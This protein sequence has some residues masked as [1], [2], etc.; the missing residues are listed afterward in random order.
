MYEIYAHTDGCAGRNVPLVECQ[1]LFRGHAG[2][3]VRY[4]GRNSKV[5]FNAC[6]EIWQLLQ[7]LPSGYAVRI[8][9]CLRQL[10]PE[11]R[12]LCGIVEE[13]KMERGQ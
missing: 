4:T 10:L 3:T 8:W 2:E 5:F 7:F 12:E 6:S 11:S 13:M 1:P 9:H